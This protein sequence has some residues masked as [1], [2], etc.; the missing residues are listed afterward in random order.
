MPNVKP[1]RWCQSFKG[2]ADERHTRRFQTMLV[3]ASARP[4]ETIAATYTVP[5][6]RQA[7]YDFVEHDTIQPDR[8]LDVIADATARGAAKHDEVLLLLD[9]SSLSLVD[10]DNAKG[11]GSVGTKTAGARGIKV[12]TS[13]VCTLDGTPIGC[14]RF[15][16]WCR[17]DENVEK[18][19]R[20]LQ[21]RESYHWHESING[22]EK[23]FSKF[24]PKTKLHIVGD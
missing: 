24:A 1:L 3:G 14:G 10:H 23:A 4:G 7:A 11:F 2:F 13:L 6:E 9:G 18:K 16:Y 15:R 22:A 8:V 19:Y 12:L 17:S 5:A 20:P 21:H